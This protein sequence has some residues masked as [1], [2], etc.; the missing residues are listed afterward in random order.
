MIIREN[1]TDKEVFEIMLLQLKDVF[2]PLNN[3]KVDKK[4]VREN[5]KITPYLKFQI[6]FVSNDFERE[7]VTSLVDYHSHL[8]LFFQVKNRQEGRHYTLNL[9]DY[10]KKYCDTN[11]S[12][13]L[14]ELPS[15]LSL[16]TSL[17]NTL[18]N[19]KSKLNKRFFNILEGKDWVEIPFDWGNYK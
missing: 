12:N 10:L 19:L 3:Y 9:S 11:E 15:N 16:E 7:V 5:E 8:R 13:N 17:G 4:E 2:D 18:S 1:N 6:T 14:L